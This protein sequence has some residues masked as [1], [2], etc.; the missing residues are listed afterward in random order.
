MLPAHILKVGNLADEFFI[1]FF[2]FNAPITFF[3]FS[4][5]LAIH[6]IGGLRPD[7]HDLN[8]GITFKD[9]HFTYPSRPDLEIF[10]GLNLEVPAGSITAVVG[11]SGSGKSTLGSLLLRLYDPGKGQVIVGGHDVRTLS[12]DWLRG[13]VGT[14]HQVLYNKFEFDM[15]HTI[16]F[17]IIHLFVLPVLSLCNLTSNHDIKGVSF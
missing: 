17:L 6:F 9:V 7:M 3:Y 11:P 14:V 4:N 12:P 8:D 1:C 13:A 15:K 2:F 5:N 16:L 10:R